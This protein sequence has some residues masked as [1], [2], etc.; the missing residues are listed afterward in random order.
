MVRPTPKEGLN[1]LVLGQEDKRQITL[2]VTSA[3][4][5]SLL[6]FQA[7]FKGK[8]SVS[9]PSQAA[10]NV[11]EVMGMPFKCGGDRHWATLETTKDWV[12]EIV[13]PYIQTVKVALQ[14]P[15]EQWT[16]HYLDA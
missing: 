11:A 4:D 5:G 1:K 6:P 15:E 9:L 12:N 10:S 7:V 2:M 16:I 8:T 3:M 14:L 13:V